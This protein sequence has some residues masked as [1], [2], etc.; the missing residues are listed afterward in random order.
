MQEKKHPSLNPDQNMDSPIIV[1]LDIGTTKVAAFVGK[2]NVHGKIE[3][4]G[5]GRTDSLGVRRGVVANIELTIQAIQKALQRASDNAG[6]DIEEVVVGIAGEHIKSIQ[7]RDSL[8]RSKEELEREITAEDVNK[9]I[10]NVYCLTVTPGEEIIHVLPQEFMVDQEAGIK[11]P[12]GFSGMRL[13][14]TFHVITGKVNP[15]KNIYKCVTRSGFEVSGLYLEP[16][17]S[18]EAVLLKEEKD[19]GVALVDIGGGTTDL[20]IFHDGVIRHTAVIPLGGRLITEDIKQAFGLIEAQA[21][22]LKVKFGSVIPEEA[23]KNE[24][25]SISGLA[26]RQPKEVS[27]FVLS[28]VIHARMTEILEFVDA[29]IENSG[30]RKRLAAGVVITGGGS[31]L[32]NLQKLASFQLGMECRLGT[33]NMHLAGDNDEYRNPSYAT[34]IG[35][36]MK[37]IEDEERKIKMKKEKEKEQPGLTAEDQSQK[38]LEKERWSLMNIINNLK[39]ITEDWIKHD[40]D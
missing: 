28:Q 33:P 31:L 13:E 4:L 27:C 32:K 20:A 29:E 12:V 22:K 37:G 1:G 15:I 8:T 9:L 38:K 6:V 24:I 23:R 16:I 5:M 17:A 18:A 3:I 40:L 14:G 30:Y 10:S 2:K 19:A 36:L 7:Y 11:D 21:E 26:N 39:N 25:V 35:L 34:G